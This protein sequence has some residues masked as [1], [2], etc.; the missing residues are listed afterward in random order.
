MAACPK[1]N[2][3][4]EQCCFLVSSYRRKISP[5]G[6][7]WDFSDQMLKLFLFLSVKGN[8]MQFTKLIYLYILR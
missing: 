6:C 5:S 3:G 7:H 2:T 1:S 8:R 4:T